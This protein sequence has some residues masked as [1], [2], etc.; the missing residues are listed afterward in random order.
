VNAN[1]ARESSGTQGGNEGGCYGRNIRMIEILDQAIARA[2]AL[3]DEDQDALGAVMLSLAEEWSSR[4]DDLDEETR[5][6]IRE[7]LAQAE[8]GEFVP[9][10]NIQALWKRYGP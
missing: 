4:A 9:H 8:R 5:A 6:V 7:G 2:R 3:S 10:E 1:G